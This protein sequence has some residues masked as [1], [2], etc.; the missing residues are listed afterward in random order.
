MHDPQRGLQPGHAERGG[1]PF[2]LLVLH[3]VRRVI[4]GDAVDRPV[5]QPGPQRVHVGLGAQRRVH[6]VDRV[7]A[8][9]QLV[10]QQQV[11]RGHLGGNPPALG[12]GPADYLHRACR[13]HVADVQRGADV[14]GQQAVTGD[15][16]FL[17]DRGPAGQPEQAGDL[18]LVDLGAVGQPRLLRVLGDHAVEGLDVLQRAPHEDRVGH[19]AAVVGEHPD[20]GGRVSHG[21]RARP[22]GCRRGPP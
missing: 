11:V 4:G 15:D 14:G 10:G 20:P 3:R 2:G 19:A 8:G 7:V 18:A 12:L 5:R 22:A 21:A 16:G 1:L 9:G 6:L 17:G 13:R